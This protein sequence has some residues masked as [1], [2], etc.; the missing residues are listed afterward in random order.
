[1]IYSYLVVQ[2]NVTISQIAYKIP[3]D[4]TPSWV[5]KYEG[6]KIIRFVQLARTILIKL[7]WDQL[8]NLG[9]KTSIS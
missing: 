4:D 7:K 5:V 9:R 3:C 1:M 8:L 6:K 2:I